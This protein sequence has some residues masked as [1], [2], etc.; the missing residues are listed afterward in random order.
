MCRYGRW[1]RVPFLWGP[2]GLANCSQSNAGQN[3]QDDCSD[4]DY[5]EIGHGSAPVDAPPTFH[6]SASGTAFQEKGRATRGCS[7][8]RRRTALEVWLS[9]LGFGFD[10]DFA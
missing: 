7:S 10:D 5:A 8:L 4:Y 2:A 6:F 3:A 9:L 1:V